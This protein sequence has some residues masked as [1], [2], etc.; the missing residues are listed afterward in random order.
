MRGPTEH[1]KESNW[2]N[3]SMDHMRRTYQSDSEDESG[4]NHVYGHE[5]VIQTA[6]SAIQIAHGIFDGKLLTVEFPGTGE[7][8]PEPCS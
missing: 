4:D 7:T 8:N 3:D 6:D 1:D 5:D 2:G